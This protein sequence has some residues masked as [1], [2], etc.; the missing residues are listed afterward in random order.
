LLAV[1]LGLLQL[2]L[3]RV[4]EGYEILCIKIWRVYWFSRHVGVY[5]RGGALVN[6]ITQPGWHLKVNYRTSRIQLTN[7]VQV[8]WLDQFENVQ[9]TLQTDKVTN[10]PVWESALRSHTRCPL[11]ALRMLRT[12]S[13]LVLQCGTSGGVLIYFDRVEVVN[14]LKEEF[15]YHTIKNYTINYDKIWIFDKIQ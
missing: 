3:H 6:R 7:I 15:V 8:P 14:R 5:W 9:V 2:A 13:L 10:I 12:H 4:E 11:A 1:S